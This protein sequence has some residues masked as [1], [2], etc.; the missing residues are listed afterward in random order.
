MRGYTLIEA[1]ISVLLLAI[2]LLGGTALFYQNLRS[3]GFSDMDSNLNGTLQSILRA[4]EV[5]IRYSQVVA[6]A[7]GTRSECLAAGAAGYEGTE[8]TVKDLNGYETVYSLLDDKVASTSSET[9][10]KTY[11]NSTE[12][13][14]ERLN[15][16]WFCL[17]GVSD[18]IKIVIKASSNVLSTGVKVEQSA[19]SELVLLNSGLN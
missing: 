12:V 7:G 11:L 5:D 17:S 19:S 2:I 18:K 14:I 13:K 4:V 9:G 16:T 1:I 10:R 3:V 6:V 15:F 8:L